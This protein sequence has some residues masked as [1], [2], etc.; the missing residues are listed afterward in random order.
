MAMVAGTLQTPAYSWEA[1][2]VFHG[3]LGWPQ[4]WLACFWLS[5]KPKSRFLRKRSALMT[6][7]TNTWH[8]VSLNVPS[9]IRDLIQIPAIHA[10]KE[11][12]W[13]P[14]GKGKNRHR[15]LSPLLVQNNFPPRF[16]GE[17]VFLN[18]GLSQNPSFFFFFINLFI[19]GCVGSL[20]L[21]AGFLWLWRAGATLPCGARTFHCSGFSCCGARTLGARASE[22]MARGLSSCGLQAL[23]RRFSSCGAPA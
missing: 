4:N 7:A 18:P 16:S 3:G 20:L 10:W 14:K 22:A 2:R 1:L 8:W 19:F 23:E 15:E 13:V 5:Y 9:C 12:K 17:G 21:R 6:S 11:T